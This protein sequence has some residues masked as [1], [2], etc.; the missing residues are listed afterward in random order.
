MG[1]GSGSTRKGLKIHQVHELAQAKAEQ[2]NKFKRALGIPK[3]YEEGGHWKKQAEKQKA[4]MG[5]EEGAISGDSP[6]R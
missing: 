2:D 6:S 3:N 4:A 1:R 5:S